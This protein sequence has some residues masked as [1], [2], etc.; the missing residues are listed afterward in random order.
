MDNREV[1]R[2][3]V[4]LAKTIMGGSYGVF[5]AV[6]QVQKMLNVS[7]VLLSVNYSDPTRYFD[8]RKL[9][10]TVKICKVDA[11]KRFKVL[12]G[13]IPG[14]MFRGMKEAIFD[15][16]TSLTFG[17]SGAFGWDI[18]REGENPELSL[19]DLVDALEAEGWKS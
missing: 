4:R 8:S 3:L 18:V 9:I 14:F 11:Q 2:E 5:D 16:K 1:A 19:S 13:R 7:P 17:V 10:Q 12:S 15:S 6:T